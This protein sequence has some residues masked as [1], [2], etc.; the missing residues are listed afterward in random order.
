MLR[1]R[2][3]LYLAEPL[4]LDTNRVHQA[5]ALTTAHNRCYGSHVLGAAQLN[6]MRQFLQFGIGQWCQC[7]QVFMGSTD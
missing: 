6:D 4:H 7:V 2:V 5:L 3:F 1:Q